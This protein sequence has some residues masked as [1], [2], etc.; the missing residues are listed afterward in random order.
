M[1]EPNP[2]TK[3][4]SEANIRAILP[5]RYPFLLL[6]RVTEFL[7]GARIAG[8]KHFSAGDEIAQ[9]YFP[10][11]PLVPTG[12]LLELVTQLGAVLVLERP[13]MKGK[14]AMILQIPSARIIDPVKPGDTVRVEAEVLKLR[15]TFGE[16][17][18]AIYRAGE[19]V[20]EGQMRF[21]IAD[22]AALLPADRS[23]GT[24]AGAG[25]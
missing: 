15:E 25:R 3:A 14:I 7:P 1:S 20:A 6:D 4:P 22:S 18:G 9:G 23:P 12:I 13:E 10:D 17:R 8:L 11:W 19:M 24:D 21:A 2:D 16:L 5:H